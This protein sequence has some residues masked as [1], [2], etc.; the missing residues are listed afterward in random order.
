MSKNLNDTT[1]IISGG[2]GAIGCNLV[3]I[4]L[5]KHYARKIVIFDNL[6]SGDKDNLPKDL[7]V[8]LIVMDIC[9]KEKLKH[10]WPRELG[11]T[12]VFHLAAHF[13]NQNSVIFPK[14]DIDT[15]IVGTLNMLECAKEFGVDAFVNASSSCIYGGAVDMRETVKVYPTETPYAINK[16]TAELYT[17]FFQEHH[18]VPAN[19]VRIFNTYGP[20]ERGGEFRNVIPNFVDAALHNR[21]IYITGTGEETRDFTYVDDT[22]DLLILAALHGHNGIGLYNGGTGESTTIK[23]LAELI[24]EISGSSSKIS[25]ISK[26]NWDGVPHRKSNIFHSN[27]ELGY[28]PEHTDLEKNLK[29]IIDWYRNKL[30]K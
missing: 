18:G 25:Y 14:S 12:I 5:E 16:L 21:E 17:K 23:E 27:D 10:Y 7:R 9:D 24:V 20:G 19:S 6:T 4:L 29:I 26:R 8:E 1:V 11:K 13:A 2:A 15:N 30:G 28:Y 22:C 3:R